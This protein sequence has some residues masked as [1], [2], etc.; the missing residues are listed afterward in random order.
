ML[1]GTPRR[2]WTPIIDGEVA[3]IPLTQGEFAIIDL[4]DLP[5]VAPYAWRVERGPRTSYAVST[6]RRQH[7][8]MHRLIAAPPRELD[9]DHR[10]LNGLNNRRANFRPCT[11]GQNSQRRVSRKGASPFK[12]VALH[13]HSG[14]FHATINVDGRQISLGYHPTERAC[15]EAYDAGAVTHFGE[16]ALT[17][18]ELGLL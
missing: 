3:K 4:A 6:V 12:G 8:S 11:R 10:D 1:Y 14:L 9:V 16:F 7:L 17:N 15:A 5:L 13:R 2:R 18:K